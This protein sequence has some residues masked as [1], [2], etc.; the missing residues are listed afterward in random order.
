M[1][2]AIAKSPERDPGSLRLASRGSEGNIFNN[3]AVSQPRAYDRA[4]LSPHEEHRE[5]VGGRR[6]DRGRVFWG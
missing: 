5:A 2:R 6:Q 4:Q 3:P 1:N